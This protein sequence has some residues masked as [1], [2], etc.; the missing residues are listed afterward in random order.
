MALP[1]AG[2]PPAFGQL[3]LILD[4]FLANLQRV[5]NLDSQGVFTLDALKA[6]IKLSR[7][8][9]SHPLLKLVQAAAV[10]KAGRIDFDL[11]PRGL[12]GVVLAPLPRNTSMEFLPQF[13][14]DLNGPPGYRDLA[15]GLASLSEQCHFLALDF[16][17]EG[18]GFS[19][20]LRAH[21]HQLTALKETGRHPAGLRI[22]LEPLQ[23]LSLPPDRV[24]LAPLPVTVNRGE[25]NGPDRGPR[26]FCVL[27]HGVLLDP[28]S[29]DAERVVV[30]DDS[31]PTDLSEFRLQQGPQ[32]SAA[33]ERARASL[34]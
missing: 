14:K 16:W 3:W 33:M 26:A 1:R 6:R 7:Y 15:L 24:L 18:E 30:V 4:D 20:A 32:L 10:L 13:L 2:I 11:R 31:L 19:L 21:E 29:W 28:V 22:T 17:R 5:G 27:R 25:L 8:R 12:G 23:P 34:G 9:L